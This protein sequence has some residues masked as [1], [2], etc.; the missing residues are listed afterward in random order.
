MHLESK[1]DLR[2]GEQLNLVAVSVAEQLEDPLSDEV[3][4]P[5][6]ELGRHRVVER[7][8]SRVILSVASGHRVGSELPAHVCAV[9]AP[10]VHFYH[11]LYDSAGLSSSS[12]DATTSLVALRWW[13]VPPE[14]VPSRAALESQARQ[15]LELAR[16]RTGASVERMVKTFGEFQPRGAETRRSWYDWQERPETVSLLTG[17]AA[18]HALGPHAAME[19]LFGDP[20]RV[21]AS[22]DSATRDERMDQL[23][24]AVEG[25]MTEL[26]QL[27][28]RMDDFVVPEVQRQGQ[29]LA[30]VLADLKDAGVLT[31]G[32]E[33]TLEDEGRAAER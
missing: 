1:C 5:Q 32:E 8:R 6:F 22:A 30:K 27:R 26:M 18:I 10:H 11:T 31:I 17:L 24:D 16:K 20:A 25:A 13:P 3:D 23:Q 28:E 33:Q 7:R 4:E 19:L 12:W 9:L 14:P 15:L 21:D 2:D 29:L